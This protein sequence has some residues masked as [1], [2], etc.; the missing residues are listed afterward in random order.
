M[1]GR[2]K[3]IVSGYVRKIQLLFSS[4]QAYYTI[5]DLIQS[6]ILLFYYGEYFAFKGKDMNLNAQMNEI[7]YSSLCSANTA[8]G[9]INVTSDLRDITLIW[10]FEFLDLE[11][12]GSG[13]MISIGIDSSNR[14]ALNE[15]LTHYGYNRMNKWFYVIQTE[16]FNETG[17]GKMLTDTNDPE[18]SGRPRRIVKE[19]NKENALQM[20]LDVSAK[21]LRFIYEGKSFVFKNIKFEETIVYNMAVC[22]HSGS[23]TIALTD[24]SQIRSKN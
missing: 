20:I 11:M 8:Y 10:K 13:G 22:I 23:A 16:Y 21:E 19:F 5:S 14:N 18:Q 17:K 3:S 6:I 12:R 9:N 24:F 2:D 15:S 4:E 1:N 7:S